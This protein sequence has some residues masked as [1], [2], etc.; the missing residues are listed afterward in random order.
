MTIFRVKMRYV[1][2]ETIEVEADD[3]DH[4]IERAGNEIDC[5][6]HG[7]IV[8]WNAESVKEFVP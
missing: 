4:A 3:R 2:V 6:P 5:S 7:E 8:D 1:V